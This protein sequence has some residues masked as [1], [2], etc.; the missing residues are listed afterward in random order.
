MAKKFKNTNIFQDG[1]SVNA[2]TPI[3]D[4]LVFDSSSDLYI[5]SSSPATAPLY[6]VAYKGMNVVVLNGG[7]PQQYILNDETPYK[8]GSTVSVTASNLLTYWSLVGKIENDFINNV[9]NTSINKLENRET[10]S[11]V[12][13]GKLDSS[14]KSITSYVYSN[15]DASISTLKSNLSRTDTSLDSLTTNYNAYKTSNDASINRLDGSVNY[16]NSSLLDVRNI[17]T[18]N[19]KTIAQALTVID[20]SVNK[21]K[22]RSDTE[23]SSI[24]KLINTV[25]SNQTAVNNHFT[26]SDSSIKKLETRSDNEDASIN[27]LESSQAVQ[28]TSIGNLTTTTEKLNASINTVQGNVNT[29]KSYIDASL[30][31][32]DS[33]VEYLDTSL[34]YINSQIIDNE[35]IVAQALNDLNDKLSSGT[36][37]NTSTGETTY[38]VYTV[39]TT[40]DT[41]LDIADTSNHVIMR[42]AD[43][44]LE[45]RYF[46]SLDI[47]NDID[48]INAS[49]N[50][51]KAV[52]GDSTATTALDTVNAS[53]STI[54]SNI[55]TLN[56]STNTLESLVST[57][58]SNVSALNADASS[59][60]SSILDIRTDV[61]N[62]SGMF[63][64]YTADTSADTDLD[65]TDSSNHVI[66]RLANGHIQTKYFNSYDYSS[67]DVTNIINASAGTQ[68]TSSNFDEY[69]SYDSFSK[70]KLVALD[71]DNTRFDVNLGRVSTLSTADNSTY[72]AA[73]YIKN[74]LI[75]N[76]VDDT[77]YKISQNYVII[78]Y[79]TSTNTITVLDKH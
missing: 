51:I 36:T 14:V 35:Y 52:L 42:L 59:L 40:A 21:L 45:T 2:H 55:S 43:G 44:H 32:L 54:K 25:T 27:K 68:L 72:G 5:S 70:S 9:I 50:N 62:L 12:S 56:T 34:Y 74:S 30:T 33:S 16:L 6:K 46:N 47:S 69:L 29:L 48:N 63:N 67:F 49:I 15:V 60:E 58:K 76:S 26:I 75:Y 8:Y 20:T 10:T 78:A 24:N 61:S 71:S 57:L 19:E 79:D 73:K 37:T 28:N 18:N 4:R 17:I 38:G 39:D 64:I 31:A 66:M 3:D 77:T 23:D 22:E 65:I 13:I 1:I 11:E 53:I 7:V 41:D